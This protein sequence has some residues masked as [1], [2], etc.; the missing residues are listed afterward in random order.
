MENL[1][2][3]QIRDIILSL[4]EEPTAG[5]SKPTVSTTDY[6]SAYQ[7]SKVTFVKQAYFLGLIDSKTDDKEKGLF[8]FSRF[9][10]SNEDK[11]KRVLELIKY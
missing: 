11:H 7:E 6:Q 3:E 10:K 2:P 1:S 5:R 4:S 8:G 9:S